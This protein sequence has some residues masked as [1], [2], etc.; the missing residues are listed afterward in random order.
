MNGPVSPDGSGTVR[1]VS[2]LMS[3]SA[4]R[5]RHLDDRIAPVMAGSFRIWAS[6]MAPASSDMRAP[7]PQ[8]WQSWSD[9]SSRPAGVR[10]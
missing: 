4:S 2:P 5:I 9:V 1:K 8:S 6:A 10:A 3:A 7:T